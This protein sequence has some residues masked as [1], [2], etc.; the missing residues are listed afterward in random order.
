MLGERERAHKG[1]MQHPSTERATAM[2]RTPHGPALCGASGPPRAARSSPSAPPG[3]RLG[4][5]RSTGSQQRIFGAALAGHAPWFWAGRGREGSIEAKMLTSAIWTAL[6]GPWTRVLGCRHSGNPDMRR[7][8]FG[9]AAQIAGQIA[10]PRQF[11]TLGSAF[12]G[13]C[14]R[15]TEKPLRNG[16]FLPCT[17]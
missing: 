4:H 3:R 16:G 12:L 1:V 17:C 9:P 11:S 10:G 7:S 15:D 8:R 2:V 14:S 13:T 5:A 6:N